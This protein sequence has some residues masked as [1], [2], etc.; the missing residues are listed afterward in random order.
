MRKLI[1]FASVIVLS[2][3][4]AGAHAGHTHKMMGTVKAVHQDLNHVELTAPGGKT[5]GFYVNSSTMYMR[6]SAMATLADLTPGTRV[7]VE[8]TM[9]GDKM[10]A[11]HVKLSAARTKAATTTAAPHKKY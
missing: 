8:G 7:V 5:A 9:D 6:G 3:G 4:L 2:A 10:T 11:T 1:A